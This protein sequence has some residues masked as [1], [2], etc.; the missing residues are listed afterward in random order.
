M[1]EGVKIVFFK[2]FC[3]MNFRIIDRNLS[4]KWCYEYLKKFFGKILL[5]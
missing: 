3:L 4:G 5:V 2:V 1:K